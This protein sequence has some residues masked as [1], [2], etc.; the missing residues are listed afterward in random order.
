MKKILISGAT[1]L[2]GKKLSRKL[3]ERGYQVETLVRSRSKRSSFK[4]YVWDYENG[5]LEEGALDNTY[6]FI[7][8][9]GAPISKRWTESYKKEIYTSRI[10]SA[11]FIYEQMQKQNI[12]PE[13]IISAS[14][15]GFYGQITSGH[16]FSEEDLPAEDFLGRVCNDW[17]QKALQFQNLGSRVVRVRTTTVLSEKGGALEVLRKPIDF[18]IGSALGTGQQYFPW[19]HIDDLVDIYFKAVEDV[20]MNGAYNASAPD[21]VT[22]ETLT[23]KLAS[24]L[25]KRIWLPNIPKF[26]IKAIL[27]EM[28]VLALEG[29]R[30]SSRKIED[31][32]FKFKYSNLDSALSDI[33]N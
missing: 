5:F 7:H 2:V 22:N 23:E 3:Y 1:G 14:A 8:L 20:S 15:V 12:H 31:L 26:L 4:S 33:L 11:Q 28:S 25:H 21:F 17:E 13:A 27:G 6:I 18:N 9:A 30:I 10:N 24:H 16:I 29:S 32:G 19:I